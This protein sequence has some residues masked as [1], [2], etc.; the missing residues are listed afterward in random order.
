MKRIVF[1]FALS[2]LFAAPLLGAP[3]YP[4]DE[5]LVRAKFV[6]IADVSAFDGKTVSLKVQSKLRGDLDT[7]TLSFKVDTALGKP[8]KGQ[9]YF[10]FSQGH[11]QWGKP[12]DEI[13]LSQGLHGQ[14]SYCGWLMLRI[15]REN[16]VNMVKNAYSFKFRKPEDG[17]GP[18]TLA[19]A[20]QLVTQT[21]FKGARECVNEESGAL[22]KDV[23]PVIGTAIA[24][25]SQ[26]GGKWSVRLSVPKVTWEGV[27]VFRVKREWPKF[28]VTV[29][30]VVLEL[31]MGYQEHHK[32]GRAL[33]QLSDNSQNRVLDLQGRRLGSDEALKR[34]AA[35]TPVLVSV[36]GQMPDP[37]YLQC[38]KPDT[39]IVVLG[40][41][42]Y[43]APEL[44]PNPK[45]AKEIIEDTR[46]R[47]MLHPIQ[48]K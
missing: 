23:P 35:K 15:Y 12:K 10:V 39:L 4:L 34:L 17:I 14:G 28:K 42:S 1:A 45:A 5:L 40:I 46:N 6:C 22:P 32:G 37:F 36:S 13:R 30:E 9:R 41:P 3:A 20:Q 2:C 44:L 48:K 31:P 19:Q 47:K 8:E 21:K 7:D 16:G 33:T 24:T 18:V 11:D 27:G 43:P 38:T 26:P 29:Q 25:K